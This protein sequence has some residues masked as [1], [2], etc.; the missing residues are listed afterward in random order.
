MFGY[1]LEI[2]I[3]NDYKFLNE[4]NDW[5]TVDKTVDGDL[6]RHWPEICN[7]RRMTVI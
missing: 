4:M 7:G 6:T 1:F 2:V 5:R 3:L